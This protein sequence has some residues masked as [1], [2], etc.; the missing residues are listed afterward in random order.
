VLAWQTQISQAAERAHW[1]CAEFIAVP[2]LDALGAV[3]AIIARDFAP[4]YGIKGFETLFWPEESEDAAMDAW[5]SGLHLGS[6]ADDSPGRAAGAFIDGESLPA[7]WT[8]RFAS[9]EPRIAPRANGARPAVFLSYSTRDRERAFVACQLLEEEGIGCWIAPRDIAPGRE[10]AEAIVTGI[11]QT[12]VTVVLL[13]AG[14]NLSRYVL[15][16][17]ELSVS[18]GH[19][20]IPVRLEECRLNDSIR[21]F[22]ATHQWFDAMLPPFERHVRRLAESLRSLLR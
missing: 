6:F 19:P 7:A 2:N 17:L 8:C 10:W 16:E 21:F 1:R 22:L 18:D 20:L 3:E 5:L 11:E 13:S 12:Q 4:S 9:K 14:S 15:R